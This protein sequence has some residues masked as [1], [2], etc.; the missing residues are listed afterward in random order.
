MEC[1]EEMNQE[2]KTR[3]KEISLQKN[4]LHYRREVLET[5]RSVSF[6][7]KMNII[8]QFTKVQEHQQQITIKLLARE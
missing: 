8:L 1:M 3:V 4:L 7:H 5:V 6:F 2:T